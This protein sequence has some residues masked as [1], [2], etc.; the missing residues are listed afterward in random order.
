[1][2]DK[3]DKHKRTI[4]GI[5]PIQTLKSAVYLCKVALAIGN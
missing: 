4:F 2:I 5:I 3:Q 1:M